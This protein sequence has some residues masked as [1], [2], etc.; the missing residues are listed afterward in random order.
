MILADSCASLSSG[1]P[2]GVGDDIGPTTIDAPG[3]ATATGYRALVPQSTALTLSWLVLTMGN[4]P[5]EL[6]R[7]VESAQ[8]GGF[9][10]V[11]VSN[12]AGPIA[13]DQARVVETDTNLGV[14]G[15]RDLAAS[16]VDSDLLGFLD[17]DATLADGVTARII[18][19]FEADD[20]LGAVSLRLVDEVGSTSRRHVP[21]LG[22]RGA[23]E[24]GEVALFLG[25]ACAVRAE[26]YRDAGGYFTE[27]FYGHEELELS[28]RLIDRGWGVRYLAEAEVFHP[29]T[30]ISR[31][32]D[33][34]RLTGRNRV[35]IAR[36]TLPWPIA[37]VH[38]VAWLGVGLRRAPAGQCRRAYLAGWR[39]GWSGTLDRSPIRWRTVWRLTRI[40]RPPVV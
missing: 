16:S 35:W 5:D 13:V 19:A 12:G 31:H 15:G 33:G 3:P 21:R 37:I 34:W 9:D 28:W 1:S 39:S 17:D 22:A 20:R 36:R 25:G 6:R 18:A 29:S 10:V 24:S 40:G 14:P 30:E 26:A 32:A 27:L 38:V 4:R 8:R 2:T 23:D 7:A 11:V